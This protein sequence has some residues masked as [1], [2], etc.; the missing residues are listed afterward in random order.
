MILNAVSLHW[1]IPT[2][3]NIKKQEYIITELPAP[4][5]GKTWS[6]FEKQYSRP[7]A[8]EITAGQR[9]MSAEISALTAWNILWPVTLTSNFLFICSVYS[10]YSN[11]KA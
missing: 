10:F 9:S 1:V 6:T 7:T 8:L 2:Q 5:D 4:F 11:L 3:W